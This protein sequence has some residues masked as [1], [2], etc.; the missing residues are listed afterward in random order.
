MKPLHFLFCALLMCGTSS[1][2]FA[3]KSFPKSGIADQKSI[4][5]AFTNATIYSRYDKKI[6]N[7]TLLV[8]DGKVEA[9]GQ[10]IS[11]PPDAIVQSVQGKVIYPAFIDLYSNYG[12]PDPKAVGTRPKTQPQML[13]NNKGAYS[14][15]EALKPE[16]TAAEHFK[17]DDKKAALLRKAGF[18]AVM[19]HQMDGISRGKSAFVLLGKERA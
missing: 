15:N 8:R 2:L 12:L 1:I 9:V 14:W 17:V 6:E 10:N 4:T 19:T 5:Y 18:G 11:L 7:A 16:F 13:S 3:Q